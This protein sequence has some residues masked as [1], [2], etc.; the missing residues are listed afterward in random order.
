MSA[1]C[2]VD[3]RCHDEHY[4]ERACAQHVGSSKGG[5][6]EQ[7]PEE[8]E[9]REDG[10]GGG[11]GA[12]EVQLPRGEEDPDRDRDGAL[13]DHGA[14][15]V[16]DGQGVFV[17]AEPDHRVELL[18]QFGCHGGEDQRDDARGYTDGPREVFYGPHKEVGAEAH[19][20]D[21]AYQLRGDGPGWPL[22]ATGPEY[23]ALG[24]VSFG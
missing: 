1:A 9:A 3:D 20:R 17:V 11:E 4:V 24:D 21:R 23:E 19:H 5:F 12:Q 18:G 14:R 10:E 8:N 6:A 13:E 2:E 22:G 15:D 7:E 16:A